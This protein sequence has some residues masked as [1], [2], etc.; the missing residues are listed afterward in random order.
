MTVQTYIL[1]L[2]T[3]DSD[4]QDYLDKNLPDPRK[5]LGSKN[6]VTRTWKLL[7]DQIARQ[8]PR[9]TDL[10]LLIVQ[11]DRQV[12]PKALL[13]DKNN[14][15]IVFNKA[16]GTLQAYSL[17]KTEKEGSSFEVYRLI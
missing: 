14:R 8:I 7:F 6:S 15:N 5:Y 3:S 16:L 4:L 11:L 9:A 10:L 1:E 12:I 2:K 17:I 13:K